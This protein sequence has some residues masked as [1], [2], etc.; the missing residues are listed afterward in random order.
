MLLEHLQLKPGERVLDI[1]SGA[2]ITTIAASSLVG[3][4]GEVIGADISAPLVSYSTQRAADEAILNVRF[5][6]ADVQEEQI[7]GA[8][9]DVALSQF[10]V[11]FFESPQTAFGNIRRQLREGGRL[12]FACWQVAENNKWHLS[13][14]LGPFLPPAPPPAPGTSAVGPFSLGDPEHT[15]GILAEAGFH[16]IAHTPL[17]LVANVG[18]DAIVDED[19]LVFL[20]VAEDRLPAARE[21]VAAHL[22]QFERPDGRYDAPLAVQIFIATT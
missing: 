21:A 4:T 22:A 18:S 14:A 9:F 7:P 10:G 20:G 12:G 11:M 1:G 17:D 2:G 16:D 3:E 15:K 19:Q 13:R 8:P 5:V 6:V